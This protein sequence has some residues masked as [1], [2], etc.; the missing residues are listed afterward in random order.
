MKNGKLALDIQTITIGTVTALFF[1]VLIFNLYSFIFQVETENGRI[2][3]YPNEHLAEIRE[4]TKKK[5]QKDFV[6][7]LWRRD[8]EYFW[9]GEF[10]FALK[11]KIIQFFK[12]LLLRRIKE[13]ATGF[14]CK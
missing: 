10:P 11:S 3:I 5:N 14:R 13:K 12:Y 8:I 6:F 1:T 2:S 9:F 7:F 4:P